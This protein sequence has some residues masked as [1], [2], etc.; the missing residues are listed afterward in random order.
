M[1]HT[2]AGKLLKTALPSKYRDH[3][4][5]AVSV[6]TADKQM[7]T[8]DLTARAQADRRRSR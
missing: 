5:A 1:D 8:V 4:I 3:L 7:K 6:K 2:A